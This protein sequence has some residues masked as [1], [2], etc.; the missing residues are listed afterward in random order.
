MAAGK[1]FQHGK[2]VKPSRLKAAVE[3]GSRG[4]KK[5]GPAR[6]RALTGAKRT[7]IAAHAAKKRWGKNTAY[8]NP[9]FYKKKV[10]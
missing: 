7:E 9:A 1:R 8:S 10:R 5:G 3:L 6:A 4:G 2:K